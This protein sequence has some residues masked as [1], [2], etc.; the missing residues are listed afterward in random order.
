MQ[1][2]MNLT[3]I[4]ILLRIHW[5]LSVIGMEGAA[6]WLGRMV[7]KRV[8]AE[9][10]KLEEERTSRKQI[11]PVPVDTLPVWNWTEIESRVKTNN[12][13]LIVVDDIVHDC[14][15]FVGNHPGGISIIMKRNGKDATIDFNGGVQR[16]TKAARNLLSQ[17]R[18]AK[19]PTHQC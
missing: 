12:E 16:H 5:V 4:W 17:L 11:Q 6:K 8:D 9:A 1:A 7:Q 19:L 10:K 3:P 18:V 2:I 15:E 13:I 14:K